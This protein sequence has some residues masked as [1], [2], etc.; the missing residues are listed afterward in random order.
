M[1]QQDQNVC[2]YNK[3]GFCKFRTTC[4]KQHIKKICSKNGCESEKCYLRHP[5]VC[6]YYREIGYCKFGEWCLFKHESN[7]NKKMEE[8]IKKA[9]SEIEK[10]KNDLTILK[11]KI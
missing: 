8:A 10:H 5:K 11:R 9:E 3:Y 7:V 4:R 1:A 2:K 6:R